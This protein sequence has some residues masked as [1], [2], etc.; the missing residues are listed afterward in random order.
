MQ[1]KIDEYKIDLYKYRIYTAMEDL[2]VAQQ[3]SSISKFRAANNRA[4]YSIFAE[5]IRHESDYDD[6]Y[7]ASKDETLSLIA[8]AENLIT[9][10]KNYCDT[11]ITNATL[12]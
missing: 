1:H 5:D 11:R 2:E 8:T 12:D 4:Y 10:I 9:L 6:F 7:I 3:L